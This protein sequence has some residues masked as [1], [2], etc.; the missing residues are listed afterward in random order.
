MTDRSVSPQQL[1][2]AQTL[3]SQYARR[4][5]DVGGDPR[6]ARL[7]W[8]SSLL[9]REIASFKELG[10]EEGKRVIDAL[11]LALGIADRDRARAMGTHGRRRMTPRRLSLMASQ[12]DRNRIHMRPLA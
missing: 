2:K 9:G 5:L 8:A 12:S 3:W 7:A 6:T 11:N 4:S 10:S 1:A